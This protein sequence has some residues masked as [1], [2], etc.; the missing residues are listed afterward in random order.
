MKSI[1]KLH[2]NEIKLASGGSCDCYC[3]RGPS[4]EYY[5]GPVNT[6]EYCREACDGHGGDWKFDKCVPCSKGDKKI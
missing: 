3:W 5:I 2:Y 4:D 6:E 1:I